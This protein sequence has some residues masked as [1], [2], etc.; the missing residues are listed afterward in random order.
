MNEEK[1]D[2]GNSFRFPDANLE[3]DS[4]NATI[5]EDETAAFS[6]PVNLHVHHVRKRATDIDGLSIKATLDGLVASG[7]L[8][9]DSPKWI[10]SIKTTASKGEVEK[11]IFR[12]EEI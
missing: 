10:K 7:I 8:P 4:S 3:P 9:D 12:F 6:S 11:T 5:S 1:K 2:C